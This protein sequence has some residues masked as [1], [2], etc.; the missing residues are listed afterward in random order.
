MSQ[1]PMTQPAPFLPG[2]CFPTPKPFNFDPHT[3]LPIEYDT[4]GNPYSPIVLVDPPELPEGV[5]GYDP[6]TG[7][8]LDEHGHPVYGEHNPFG[9]HTFTTRLEDRGG[10]DPAGHVIAQR[11]LYDTHNGQPIHY[12]E[13][14]VGMV[15][16][17]GVVL[18]EGVAGFDPYTGVPVDEHGEPVSGADNPHLRPQY[19]SETGL[20][21]TYDDHGNPL[22]PNVHVENPPGVDGYD[23]ITGQPLDEYGVPVEGAVNPNWRPEDRPEPEHEGLPNFDP[24]TGFPLEYDEHG[25]PY[26]AVDLGYTPTLP[27]GVAG[28][29]P[30]TG[31]PVDE[32]GKVVEG[33]D[34]P[35]GDHTFTTNL[36]DREGVDPAGHVVAQRPMYDE[37]TGLP[38]YYDGQGQPYV[39][40]VDTEKPD[41]VY[42]YDEKTGEPLDPFGH[43]VDGVENPYQRPNYDASTGRPIQYDQNGYQVPQPPV[44]L[45]PKPEDVVGYDPRTGEPV[46]EDGDPVDGAINPW[47]LDENDLM[48]PGPRTPEEPEDLNQPNIGEDDGTIVDEPGNTG[49]F[50][51]GTEILVDPPVDEMG[52][53]GDIFGKTESPAEPTDPTVPTTE[54]TDPM[55]P[56]TVPTD[57]KV[58]VPEPRDTDDEDPFAHTEAPKETV[59]TTVKDSDDDG[60]FRDEPTSH[61]PVATEPAET[62]ASHESSSLDDAPDSGADAADHADPVAAG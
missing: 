48:Y 33:V 45:P 19:D 23:P 20:P 18:P 42:R 24:E 54:P 60:G 22:V 34:N 52:E 26:P 7:K 14:G 27:D 44:Y 39:F 13:N 21:I 49:P 6:Y 11:P 4:H 57:G 10:V 28:Y 38:I 36:S 17:I 58:T 32:H 47:L 50:A 25:N 40:N 30:Y 15:N 37:D 31:E 41:G 56:T 62:T 3:G 35:H 29:D 61:E 59:A 16:L 55:V 12:D 43:V 9:Q 53:P 5:T 2:G 51:P 8:P 46:D 1:L